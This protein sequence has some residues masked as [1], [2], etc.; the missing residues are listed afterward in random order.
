VLPGAPDPPVW[1]I[2]GTAATSEVANTS[3]ASATL[4]R[5]LSLF[6]RKPFSFVGLRG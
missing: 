2:A 6:D 3:P 4:R 1:A 5:L